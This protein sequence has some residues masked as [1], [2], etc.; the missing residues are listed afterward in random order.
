M[1]RAAAEESGVVDET[2]RVLRVGRAARS[3]QAADVGARRR[4]I[5][6]AH[7]VTTARPG[8]NIE[9]V[10]GGL[11][12][13][14]RDQRRVICRRIESRRIRAMVPGGGDDDDAGIPCPIERGRE[15][16]GRGGR[17]DTAVE[18]DR[19]DVDVER[20]GIGDD[21]IDGID[22]P[23]LRDH[24]VAAGDLH[25]HDAGTGCNAEEVPIVAGDDA[26][27]V[28][29]MSVAIAPGRARGRCVRR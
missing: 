3:A 7:A 21:P 10:R 26:R 25:R 5:G 18:G 17:T 2:F 16:I 22:H 27:Q 23:L 19:Q 24:P 29:P 28:R 9:S 15:R 13:A 12:A 20:V 8:G 4:E 14:D 6:I 1:R 11:D